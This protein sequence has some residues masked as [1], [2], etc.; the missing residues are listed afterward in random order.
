MSA[1]M[2]GIMTETYLQIVTDK[3]DS[4]TFIFIA[5]KFYESQETD[6]SRPEYKRYRR[7]RIQHITRRATFLYNCMAAWK[8]LKS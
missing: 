2:F 4:T 5:Y 1:F 6:R 3:N 8:V 7:H